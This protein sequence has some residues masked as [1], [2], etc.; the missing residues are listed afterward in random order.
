MTQ[1]LW[2][3]VD[4]Y[5]CDHLLSEDPILDA[6]LAASD[7]AGLPSIAV[8]PNQG[9]LLELLVR[10]HGARNILELGTL[11][12]YS[13]I[14]L[15]RALPAGGRLVTV[16]ANPDYAE[17][18]RANIANAN[19]AEI[20]QLRVGPALQEMPELLAEGAGP[21]DLIFI[22]A[23]KQNNPGYLE[24]SLR[25]SRPGSLIIADNVVRGGAILDPGGRDP[26]VG[27]EGIRGVRRLYELLAAEPR[28]S[29]TA[30]QT[31]GAKGHDGFAVALVT[32]G[33]SPPAEAGSSTT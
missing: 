22:D 2:T 29:A 27:V 15:A 21:F 31:V 14:W 30:I 7:A 32:G 24:W 3:A 33:Q 1:E 25:L 4:R 9:K 16:E 17:V 13:T 5:I 26:T 28:V 18:A 12:A 8:T 6:A 10:V 23:D 11:G 19:L 20:V